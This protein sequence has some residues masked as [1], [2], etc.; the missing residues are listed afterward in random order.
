[1]RQRPI[2]IG[3]LALASGYLWSMLRRLK[4]PVSRELVVFT[5]HEQMQR[6]NKF[7]TSRLSTADSGT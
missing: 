2:V 6:L 1:M 7:V 4:R 5:R 3:G